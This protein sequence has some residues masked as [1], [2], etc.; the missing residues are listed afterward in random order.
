M[1][2]FSGSFKDF[3]NL[4]KIG[5]HNTCDKKNNKNKDNATNKNID[6]NCN[7]IRNTNYIEV[8]IDFIYEN[9]S[10]NFSLN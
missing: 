2:R 10:V 4:L 5:S 8:N 3:L 7:N 1:D 9:H 6:N